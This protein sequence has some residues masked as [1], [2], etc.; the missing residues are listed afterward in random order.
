[1]LHCRIPVDGSAE[2]LDRWQTQADTSLW[3]RATFGWAAAMVGEIGAARDV[4][5]DLLALDLTVQ[6]RNA[7]WLPLLITVAD[8]V[9]EIALRDGAPAM[10][11]GD[12]RELVDRHHERIVTAF[13]GLVCLGSM[14]RVAGRLAL[15]AGDQPSAE[16]H[17][18]AAVAA[19]DRLGAV[20]LAAASRADLAVA[21]RRRHDPAADALL[22]QA[23]ETCRSRGAVA[24][25]RRLAGGSV[26][27]SLAPDAGLSAREIEVLRHLAAGRTNKEIASL[28]HISPATVQ[29]HTINLYRKIGASGRSDAAVYAVQK[30]IVT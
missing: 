25:A 4:V 19:H 7:G 18:R 24:L 26:A 9:A 15:A 28:L 14:Q 30:G 17:L 13:N 3:H 5:T 11:P 12:L 29:R 6:R 16:R 21:R 8:A 20:L 27:T 2:L 23:I 22:R 10:V 1:M